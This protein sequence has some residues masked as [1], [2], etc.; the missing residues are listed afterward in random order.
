MVLHLSRLQLTRSETRSEMS[1]ECENRE[2]ETTA[3]ESS[4]KR[5]PTTDGKLEILSF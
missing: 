2:A 3:K 1:F 4:V 5:E